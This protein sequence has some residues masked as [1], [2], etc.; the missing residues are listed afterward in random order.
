MAAL[1]FT[2]GM[3]SLD[4]DRMPV[5]CFAL[6]SFIKQWSEWIVTQDTDDEGIVRRRKRR[7]WPFHKPAKLVEEDRFQSVLGRLEASGTPA[8]RYQKSYRSGA[9]D[10]FP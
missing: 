4:P 6:D 7:P 2:R 3:V 9:G 10:Q 1:D 8:R 5:V